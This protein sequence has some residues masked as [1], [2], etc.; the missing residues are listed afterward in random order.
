MFLGIDPGKTTGLALVDL[1]SVG[2]KPV[3]EYTGQLNVEETIQWLAENAHRIKIIVCEDYRLFL[4]KARQQAGSK[5][6]ATQVI[7]A[8]RA[9][10]SI[11][12]IKVVMQPPNIKAIAEKKT[13]LK[14]PSNHAES[15]WIDAYNHVVYYLIQKGLAHG[16]RTNQ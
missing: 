10:A 6:E 14:P 1:P 13:K 16:V 5:M 11:H 8:I 15:H 4:H 12:K 9:I 7:G 2:A 3:L